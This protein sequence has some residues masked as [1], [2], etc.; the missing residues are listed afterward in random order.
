MATEDHHMS[1]LSRVP[2]PMTRELA[3]GIGA[4]A[5]GVS[6]TPGSSR[7]LEWGARLAAISGADV[8]AVHVLT[9]NHEMLRDITLDT[10]RTWRRDLRHDLEGPWT[11]PLRAMGINHRC[12]LIEADTIAAGLL[13]VCRSEHA[14][15]LVVG[16][17]DGPMSRIRGSTGRRL[18]YHPSVPVV[19]VPQSWKD[20]I[21]PVRPTATAVTY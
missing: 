18:A 21:T 5:V 15:L 7:A 10:M 12:V 19:V 16:H 2:G 3:T 4:I 20:P 1:E 6:G 13:D 8:V 14:D 11:S 17:E 9:F